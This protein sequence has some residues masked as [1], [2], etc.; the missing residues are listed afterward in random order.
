MH[1]LVIWLYIAVFISSCSSG[2]CA[3]DLPILNYLLFLYVK[4]N[5][6]SVRANFLK[7]SLPLMSKLN[8]LYM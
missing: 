7:S 2:K 5:S 6:V 4:D 8:G 1:R 3:H